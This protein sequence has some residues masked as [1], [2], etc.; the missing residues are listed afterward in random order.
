MNSC[1]MASIAKMIYEKKA[2]QNI[3]YSQSQRSLIIRI[4][5]AYLYLTAAKPASVEIVTEGDAWDACD[6]IYKWY[7]KRY[8]DKGAKKKDTRG[9]S[10]NVTIKD[11]SE[12][13]YDFDKTYEKR[14]FD[15]YFGLIDGKKPTRNED[16]LAF[17]LHVAVA[18]YLKPED[19]DTVLREY[20]FQQL[21]VRN[22]HHLAIYVT[23]SQLSL[24]PKTEALQTN[25]F[26]QVRLHYEIARA[27]LNE[28]DPMGVIEQFEAKTEHWK[29][30]FGRKA[31]ELVFEEDQTRWIREKHFGKDKQYK[32]LSSENFVGLIEQN[33]ASFTMRHKTILDDHH[34]FA[35]LFRYLFDKTT[36]SEE[37]TDDESNFSFYSFT[38]SFCC[39]HTQKKFREKIFDQV[40]KY[41]KHPTRE[42][43]VCYWLYALCLAYID[44]VYLE[45]YAYRGIIKKLSL[46]DKSWT[47]NIKQ[48]YRYNYLNA[49]GFVRGEST[50]KETYFKG[51]DVVDFIRE[52]LCNHYKWGTLDSRNE[53]DYY[54]EQLSNLEFE[55]E[56]TG[57]PINMK[58]N[59]LPVQFSKPIPDNVPCTLVVV[60]ELFKQ[61]KT[62]DEYPLKCNIYEQM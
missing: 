4:Y 38:N 54:I 61:L 3:P 22:I 35:S 62:F 30:L 8:I 46:F 53:F 37:E 47:E 58:F 57:Q 23:L 43:M 48:H 26:K 56:Y 16:F 40:D 45:D 32:E 34:K 52:K 41:G 59:G 10:K 55:I 12:G 9:I 50:K 2:K 14:Q 49:I 44:G 20:G 15:K 28:Q 39:K 36:Q 60:F 33:N 17:I 42:L 25:P 24:K 27:I 1:N 6:E 11:V 7:A 18:F 31:M 13:T 5:N 21:H 19:I 29:D 51:E